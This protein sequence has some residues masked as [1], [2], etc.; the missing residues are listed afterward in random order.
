MHNI[1]SVADLRPLSDPVVELYCKILGFPHTLLDRITGK[2]YCIWSYPVDSLTPEDCAPRPSISWDT[3]AL[4]RILDAC[5]AVNNGFIRDVRVVFIHTDA[6]KSV[7]RLDGLE[8][9][10]KLRPEIQFYLYGSSET[11][12]PLLRGVTEIYPLGMVFNYTY[13]FY[14]K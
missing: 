11:T 10:R 5:K 1:D 2:P 9:R 6:L 12:F 4:L 3:Y 13:L 8:K 7:G 14:A